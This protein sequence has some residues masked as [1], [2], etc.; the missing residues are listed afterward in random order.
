VS[1]VFILIIIK[2]IIHFWAITPRDIDPA[3]LR[4]FERKVLLDLPDASDRQ[5]MMAKYLPSFTEWSQE[6]RDEFGLATANFTGDDIRIA[7]KEATLSSIRLQISANE[8][9][10]QRKIQPD[11]LRTAFSHIQ[12][13]AQEIV[14]KHRDWN[15]DQGNRL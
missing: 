3:F 9:P 12:P 2:N 14:Q 5:L 13:L 10:T 11:N 8:K 4:R 6:V 7:C 1:L 15:R